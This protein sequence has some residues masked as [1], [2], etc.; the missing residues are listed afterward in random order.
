MIYGSLKVLTNL[1]ANNKFN[2]EFEESEVALSIPI[3]QV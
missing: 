3:W 1:P 2:A